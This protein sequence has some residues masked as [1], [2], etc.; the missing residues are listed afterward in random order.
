MSEAVRDYMYAPIGVELLNLH[1]HF[2]PALHGRG[3]KMKVNWVVPDGVH[4]LRSIRSLRMT[5]SSTLQNSPVLAVVDSPFA[6]H[7]WTK[8]MAKLDLAYHVHLREPT[9][10]R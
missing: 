7:A 6:T 5:I 10:G 2:R 4:V 1:N 9:H 3:L 8:P